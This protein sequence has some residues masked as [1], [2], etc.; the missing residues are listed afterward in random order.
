MNP[1]EIPQTDVKYFFQL[2]T[3]FKTKMVICFCM[4]CLVT[5]VK[6]CFFHLM[7]GSLCLFKLEFDLIGPSYCQKNSY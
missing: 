5:P 4:I 1:I 7:W 2:F 6:L 3:F